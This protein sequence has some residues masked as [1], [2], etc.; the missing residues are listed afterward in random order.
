MDPVA[1]RDKW[2]QALAA[3]P[4]FKDLVNWADLQKRLAMERMLRSEGDE[5]VK[6]ELR[7]EARVLSDIHRFL[8]KTMEDARNG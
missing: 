7:G 5:W 8:K 1:P 4:A 3:N 2:G 6:A